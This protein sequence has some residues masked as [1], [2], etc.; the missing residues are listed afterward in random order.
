MACCTYARTLVISTAGTF[1]PIPNRDAVRTSCATFAALR[2]ALLGTHPVQ[3]QSPPIRFFS[4]SATL[5]PSCAANPAAVNPPEPAP[6][7]TRSKSRAI[8]VLRV[9]EPAEQSHGDHSHRQSAVNEPI[10]GEPAAQH[11]CQ[12]SAANG[13]DAQQGRIDPHR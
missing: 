5:A 6:T 8:E 10:H 7:I 11:R 13:A 1:E 3:V 2:S 12:Q 4:T 9:M